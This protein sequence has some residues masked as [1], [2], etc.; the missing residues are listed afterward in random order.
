MRLLTIS[1]LGAILLVAVSP[2]ASGG[3]GAPISS[4]GQVVTSDAFLT[5]DLL[6]P[7]SAGIVVGASGITIDL[8]GFALVGDRSGHHGI[9]DS[10]GQEAVTVKNGVVRNFNFGVIGVGDRFSVVNLVASGNLIDGIFVAGNA[11]KIQSSTASGNGFRGIGVTG[12]LAL[13][14]RSTV[15]G[16]VS[17]GIGVGGKLAKIQSSTAAGNGANGIA[18][19]GQAASIQRSA[20]SGNGG[21]GILVDG[22]AAKVNG[23]RTEGNGF[24]SGASDGAG[25]GIATSGYTTP[26]VGKN[27]ARG[28]D[29]PAECDPA[30]LC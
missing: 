26:P 19:S 25:L 16:N 2:E 28:N 7:G 3:G 12:D 8:K 27:I 20:A 22:D 15:S 9:D 5:Q 23:N 30:F 13:I 17:H 18:V 4:C 6:C 10:G 24:P 14:Q 1:A 29:D 11:A 21:H